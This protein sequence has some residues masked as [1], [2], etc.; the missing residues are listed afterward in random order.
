MGDYDHNF[1]TKSIIKIIRESSPYRI[2]SEHI[3][4]GC[5]LIKFLGE[6]KHLARVITVVLYMNLNWGNVL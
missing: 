6:I 5:L 3:L 1:N 2:Q 4:L